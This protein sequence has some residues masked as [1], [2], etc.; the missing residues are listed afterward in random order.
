M[1]IN[2]SKKA[3]QQDKMR[4]SVL[5]YDETCANHPMFAQ[6]SKNHQ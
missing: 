5:F 1:F 6:V 4:K 3:P 2:S